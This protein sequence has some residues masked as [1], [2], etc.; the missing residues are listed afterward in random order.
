MTI[1][2]LLI[3]NVDYCIVLLSLNLLQVTCDSVLSLKTN[4]DDNTSIVVL[5]SFQNE[6][7]GQ[8]IDTLT[9]AHFAYIQSQLR[10]NTH[11]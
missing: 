3:F 5:V 11:L 4:T 7:L 1:L 6:R 2:Q 10:N 9:Q 8:S